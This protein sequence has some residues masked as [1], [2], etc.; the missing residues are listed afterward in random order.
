MFYFKACPK[1]CGDLYVDRDQYGTFV[2]CVQCGLV[3]DVELNR[4]F[5]SMSQAGTAPVNTSMAVSGET[6]ALTA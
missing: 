4:D 6:L 5:A 1:C 2:E 3:R